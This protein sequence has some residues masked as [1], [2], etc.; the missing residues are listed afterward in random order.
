MMAGIVGEG[1]DSWLVPGS[2]GPSVPG[3][4]VPSVFSTFSHS[5]RSGPILARG[6]A[7]LNDIMTC[8]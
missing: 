1:R 7:G 8:T 4:F 2:F 6:M 3:S 5:G